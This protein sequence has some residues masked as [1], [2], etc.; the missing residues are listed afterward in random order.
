MAAFTV[1]D[2]VAHSKLDGSVLAEVNSKTGD[3]AFMLLSDLG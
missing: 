1:V 2:A 3:D